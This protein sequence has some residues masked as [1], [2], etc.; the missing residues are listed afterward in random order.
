MKSQFTV[1]HAQSFLLILHISECISGI[2]NKHF[3]LPSDFNSSILTTTYNYKNV[4]TFDTFYTVHLFI[5]GHLKSPT[6]NYVQYFGRNKK[7]FK[8][9]VLIAKKFVLF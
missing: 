5:V 2:E 3:T 6:M 7:S 1:I 4:E 9:N 8:H